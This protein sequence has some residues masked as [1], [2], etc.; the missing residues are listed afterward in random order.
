M[1]LSLT[2]VHLRPRRGGGV[3]TSTAHSP[4]ALGNS[5][6]GTPQSR[7]AA[8]G[9]MMRLPRRD[10]KRRSFYLVDAFPLNDAAVPLPFYE[11][12]KISPPDSVS[13]PGPRRTIA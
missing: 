4:R 2:S 12:R 7:A 13:S 3:V 5:C 11:K 9:P 10:C 8:T 1:A 6:G